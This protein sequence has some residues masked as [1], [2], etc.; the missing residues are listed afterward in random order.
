MT[1]EFVASVDS[2][3]LHNNPKKYTRRELVMTET[4]ISE[5]HTSF[6]IPEI[7]KLSVNIPYVQILG[8]NHC[9]ESPQTAFKRCE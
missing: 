6:Y 2:I 4:T 7:Q 8:K 3:M 1:K 5:F 9:S